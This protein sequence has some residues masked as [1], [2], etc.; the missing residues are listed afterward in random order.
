VRDN[1][2]T[3]QYNSDAGSVVGYD[4]SSPTYNSVSINIGVYGMMTSGSSMAFSNN[5]LNLYVVDQSTTDV[6]QY[7][8]STAFDLSTA[9]MPNS[10]ALNV[11]G[12]TNVPRGVLVN[13]TGTKLYILSAAD[14]G[15]NPVNRVLE[16]TMSTAY[17]MQTATYSTSY[18]FDSAH[19]NGFDLSWGD[20]GTR[21]YTVEQ[22]SHRVHSF[23]LT[24]AYDMS[25]ASY[26]GI[27]SSMDITGR[28][29]NGQDVA[30]SADGYTIY[31]LGT[32][33][34]Y[35]FLLSTAFDLSTATYQSSSDWTG[36]NSEDTVATAMLFNDTGQKFYL[37]G[38]QNDYIY[39]YNDT[40]SV[41]YRTNT[42]WTNATTNDEFYALQQ[43]LGA[44]S[45]NRMDKTQ[46]DAVADGSHFTLGDTLDL[47]IALKQD[48]ASASLPTS[49][50]VSINYDAQ[51][52]NQG[53]VLG[54]DYDY[55][56]PD[57]TTVR[58][59]SNAAQNL[60]IRVV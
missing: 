7:V 51:A 3:W 42:T 13:N 29:T 47:A 50:G 4:L 45:V 43:A 19:T 32:T 57:S 25:T 56:F 34:V 21:F 23:T 37:L 46:L 39:E 24:T 41:G 33:S 44:T 52:L 18:N 8:L 54:T 38:R 58:I 55:D 31:V 59:T 53:A 11:G 35:K 48:T 20:S 15:G 27:N 14:T 49:D 5:G 28:T 6:Y 9:S 36:F 16:Y 1:A 40:F 26:D 30:L 22:N 60:K 17:D 2:G 12:Q 10:T